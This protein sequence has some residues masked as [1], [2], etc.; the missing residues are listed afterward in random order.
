M[1]EIKNRIDELNTKLDEAVDVYLCV[2]AVF[3]L[4]PC[5]T[6]ELGLRLAADRVSSAINR[7]EEALRQLEK[8]K[9]VVAP[10]FIVRV[11]TPKKTFDYEYVSEYNAFLAYKK[12]CLDM[13]LSRKSTRVSLSRGDTVFKSADLM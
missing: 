13:K 12:A 6:S 11:E 8:E 10:R 4:Y 7:I 2:K 1:N 9:A 3:N 5:V